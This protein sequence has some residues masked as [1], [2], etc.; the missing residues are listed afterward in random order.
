MEICLGV[1]G[2]EVP[3]RRGQNDGDDGR[4]GQGEGHRVAGAKRGCH[5][6][7]QQGEKE[8]FHVL[9]LALVRNRRDFALASFAARVCH[10]LK[11]IAD[12][13]DQ[14]GDCEDR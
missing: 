4:T 8:K 1:A 5:N 3:G 7:H 9:P 10:G 11:I 13:L 14:H 12:E 2:K 6:D